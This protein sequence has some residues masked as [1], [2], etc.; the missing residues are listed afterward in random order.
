MSWPYPIRAG[1]RVSVDTQK[2]DMTTTYNPAPATYA[3]SES[4]RQYGRPYASPEAR[5]GWYHGYGPM[6]RPNR[7]APPEPV[8]S[9]NSSSLRKAGVAAALLAAI[10]GG[11]LVGAVVFGKSGSAPAPSVYMVPETSGVPAVQPAQQP[12]PPANP[13]PRTIVV[14]GNGPTVVVPPARRVPAPAAAPAPLPPPPAAPRPV[15][16]PPPPPPAPAAPPQVRIEGIPIPI[17]MPVQPQPNEGQNNQDQQQQ[18]TPDEKTP[19]DECTEV[20][21]LPYCKQQQGGQGGQGQGG[22]DQ[23]QGQGGGQGQDQGGQQTGGAGGSA[24]DPGQFGTSKQDA[25]SAQLELPDA[26][27]GTGGSAADQNPCVDPQSLRNC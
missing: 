24:P 5:S 21:D 1:Q 23:G 17:P 2:H 11:A 3:W 20:P 6:D 15:N 7:V 16:V 9:G 13:G 19:K 22:Q 27:T 10:G 12:P 14:P 8:P 4:D 18:Q 26:L 25:G